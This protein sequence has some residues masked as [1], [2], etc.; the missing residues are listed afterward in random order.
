MANPNIKMGGGGVL[1]QETAV[2]DGKDES[3]EAATRTENK[4]EI[5]VSNHESSR[6]Q[7]SSKDEDPRAMIDNQG[8]PYAGKDPSKRA[9]KHD[10]HDDEE[11]EEGG[12]RGE[13]VSMTFPQKASFRF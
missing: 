6:I 10:N 7:Q 13:D 9:R 12:S 2:K 11:R 8:I 5:F 4:F 1:R 3:N